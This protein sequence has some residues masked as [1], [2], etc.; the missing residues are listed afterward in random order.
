MGR[1][2]Q[3]RLHHPKSERD[4]RSIIS[5]E[6]AI[7]TASQK[8]RDLKPNKVFLFQERIRRG[9]ISAKAEKAYGK[10]NWKGW[11]YLASASVFLGLFLVY[12]Y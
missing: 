4:I 7:S 12:L 10:N 6:N 9:S 5:A 11:L 1:D 2:I 8:V 3:C